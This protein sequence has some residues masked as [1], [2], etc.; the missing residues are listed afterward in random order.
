MQDRLTIERFEEEAKNQLYIFDPE[1]YF[2]LH[3]PP[4]LDSDQ[5][6][7]FVDESGEKWSEVTDPR[8]LDEFFRRRNEGREVS[9]GQ[10]TAVLA[11]NGEWM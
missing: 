2:R 1:R 9:G 5:N 8:D 11:N 6:P 7:V 4:E 3:K 10:L